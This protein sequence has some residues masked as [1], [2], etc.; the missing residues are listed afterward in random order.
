MPL[1]LQKLILVTNEALEARSCPR[2]AL[3]PNYYG[4]GLSL[5]LKTMAWASNVEV[6]A[7]LRAALIFLRHPQ[8]LGLT[9][10]VISYIIIDS[11]PPFTSF[12]ETITIQ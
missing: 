7:N 2:G 12:K 10:K 1:Q 3:K 9:S 11:L 6:L 5:G 4:L 8:T